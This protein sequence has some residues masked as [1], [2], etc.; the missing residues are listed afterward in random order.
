MNSAW[1]S[2]TSISSNTIPCCP[3]TT[4][5]LPV[6]W[7]AGDAY[8]S[9]K[10]SICFKHLCYNSTPTAWS[11]GVVR[12][13]RN[14]LWA[15][16]W[17]I[18][19]TSWVKATPLQNLLPVGRKAMAVAIKHGKANKNVKSEAFASTMKVAN[20]SILMFWN[21]M[22]KTTSYCRWPR[23]C[24]KPNCSNRITLCIKPKITV[25]KQLRKPTSIKWFL[26]NAWS[27][28]FHRK[29]TRMV[30]K[31]LEISMTWTIL[32]SIS[33]VKKTTLRGIKPRSL[34]WQSRILTVILQS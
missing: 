18:S 19:N 14:L 3:T 28:P 24:V 17:A 33:F 30:T 25:L 7:L 2:V 20:N 15:I 4:S 16:V 1:K 12:T 10:H 31:P 9:A 11:S 29:P 5:L 27:P 34:D 26:A 23:V 22:W 32:A 8:Y 21:K 13:T 6:L